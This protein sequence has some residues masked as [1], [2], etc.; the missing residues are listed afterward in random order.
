MLLVANLSALHLPGSWFV[1]TISVAITLFLPTAVLAGYAIGQIYAFLLGK[2]S[3]PRKAAFQGTFAV[4]GVAAVLLAARALL[5]ILLPST[6]LFRYADRPAMAWI[7]QNIPPGETILINP[8]YWGY[9]T[10]A[11]ADGGYWITP[12]TGHKTLPPP[13]L[14]QAVMDQAADP[15]G[16][17]ETL[18]SQGIHYVYLGARGG[19]LSPQALR[20]SEQFEALYAQQGVWIFEVRKK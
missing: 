9:N 13:V 19:I 4:L 12:L 16:L 1:N 10:Y 5:P 15:A 6:D 8:M 11:G 14:Y 20:E 17:A 2:I 18:R 3:L 7:E